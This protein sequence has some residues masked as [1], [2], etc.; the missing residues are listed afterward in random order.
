M[1]ERY[2]FSYM[3]ACFS[4]VS[5][6]IISLNG[7]RNSFVHVIESKLLKSAH[8][9]AAYLVILMEAKN[10]IFKRK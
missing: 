8:A 3:T 10:H 1:R 2:I 5:R 4:S 9:S 6:Y 7:V